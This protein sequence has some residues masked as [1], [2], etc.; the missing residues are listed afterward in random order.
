M[1]PVFL[2]HTCSR[3]RNQHYS[4]SHMAWAISRLN[5]KFRYKR[6][7]ARPD[8]FSCQSTSM[9]SRPHCY[10]ADLQCISIYSVSLYIQCISGLE[11]GTAIAAASFQALEHKITPCLDKYNT[12]LKFSTWYAFSKFQTQSVNKLFTYKNIP[13]H[14][15]CSTFMFMPPDY[16]RNQSRKTKGVSYI[17]YE[18]HVQMYIKVTSNGGKKHK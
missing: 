9:E 6:S 10:W 12:K 17:H 8:S 4:V 11:S 13:P 2:L 3:S 5:R 1:L 7:V 14:D 16:F 15:G 18:L